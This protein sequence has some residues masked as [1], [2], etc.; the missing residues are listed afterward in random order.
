MVLFILLQ[1][2]EKD[3]SL[4]PIPSLYTGASMS[5]VI[6]L[7]NQQLYRNSRTN[8]TKFLSDVAELENVIYCLPIAATQKRILL[9]LVHP[10][11]KYLDHWLVFWHNSLCVKREPIKNWLNKL[12]L[13]KNLRTTLWG[14]VDGRATAKEILKSG[15]LSDEDAFRLACINCMPNEVMSLWPRVK[16]YFVH[17]V[18][19]KKDLSESSEVIV[20]SRYANEANSDENENLNP[21]AFRWY[22]CSDAWYEFAVRSAVKEGNELAMDYFLNKIHFYMRGIIVQGVAESVFNGL[23]GPYNA[24]SI[25]L[26]ISHLGLQKWSEFVKTHAE[27]VF[28]TFTE[29][30]MCIFFFEMALESRKNLTSQQ[31]L[32]M[33][34]RLATYVEPSENGPIGDYLLDQVKDI[35][36]AVWKNTSNEQ[37][38][39]VIQLLLE[40]DTNC[41]I[42]SST[43]L[44]N[45]MKKNSWVF[46]EAFTHS[47]GLY[48][49]LY[50]GF[51]KNTTC[52]RETLHKYLPSCKDSEE[53]E[54]MLNMYEDKTQLPN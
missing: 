43:T 25:R 47:E 29:W 44:L 28:L 49:F 2:M 16:S 46:E 50:L 9:S 39:E 33:L 26:V 40:Y 54:Y 42:R 23:W 52:L 34:A 35:L 1:V 31:L 22:D 21:Y 51:R 4:F 18:Y 14:T 17:K 24:V 19:N 41:Q 45:E 36:E 20:F 53:V 27:Y 30:P 6:H 13:I 15:T 11:L 8:P 7:W 3:T 12:N 32:N 5:A 37:K 38:L 48:N 10:I